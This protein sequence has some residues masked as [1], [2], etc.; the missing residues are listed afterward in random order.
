MEATSTAVVVNRSDASFG[1]IDGRGLAGQAISTGDFESPVSGVLVRASLRHGT[2]D[3]VTRWTLFSSLLPVTD[4]GQPSGLMSRL[5][6]RAA[7]PW[8]F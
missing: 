4:G 6:R 8:P 5:D 7:W 2:R 3:K 1:G